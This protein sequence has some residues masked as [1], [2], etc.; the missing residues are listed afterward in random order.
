MKPCG[1]VYMAFGDRA[2]PHVRASIATLREFAP[3]LPVCVVGDVEVPGAEFIPWDGPS[4]FE[5]TEATN[6]QFRAGRVKPRLYHLSPYRKT[7]YIDADTEFVSDPMPGFTLLDNWDMAIAMH[8]AENIAQL[9]NKPKAAWFHN[10]RERDYTMEQ[11]DGGDVPYWN[12]GVIFFRKCKAVQSIFDAWPE[13]WLR[14][15]QWDEQQAL[16][17]V[18][19]QRPCRICTLPV[20]WNSPHRKQAVIIFHNYGRGVVR[21]NVS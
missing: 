17:R 7:L 5:A 4:P 3:D 16:M 11:W 9:Y 14:F 18:A 10:M 6:F 1:V 21:S 20:G 19:Y 15:N 13:E 2:I 12:S 8:P